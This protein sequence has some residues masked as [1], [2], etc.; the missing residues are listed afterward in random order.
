MVKRTVQKFRGEQVREIPMTDSSNG[1]KAS[2]RTEHVTTKI[3]PPF[4]F[5]QLMMD[6]QSQV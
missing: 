1:R 4:P 3:V 6:E 2:G 5:S